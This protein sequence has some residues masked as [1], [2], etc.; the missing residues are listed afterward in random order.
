MRHKT[1]SHSFRQQGATKNW[2]GGGFFLFCQ[3]GS[4]LVII[5]EH[6]RTTSAKTL[7]TDFWSCFFANCFQIPAWIKRELRDV[8]DDASDHSDDDVMT[9]RGT[10]DAQDASMTSIH[11]NK[12]LRLGREFRLVENQ[13]SIVTSV[14]GGTLLQAERPIWVAQMSLCCLAQQQT[15]PPFP[16]SSTPIKRHPCLD[17]VPHRMLTHWSRNYSCINVWR[18]SA[19]LLTLVIVVVFFWTEVQRP[20]RDLVFMP[21]TKSVC[22]CF[23]RGIMTRAEKENKI[24]RGEKTIALDFIRVAKHKL[25]RICC[26]LLF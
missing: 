2:G 18:W 17:H 20:V 6:D 10:S 24:A 22:L 1:M 21:R 16:G 14:L 5:C 19:L 15:P 23:S 11:I 4:A 13:T 12:D 25:L 9:E 26:E 3:G 8:N 7:K